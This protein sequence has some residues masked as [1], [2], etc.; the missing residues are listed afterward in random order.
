VIFDSDSEFSSDTVLLDW[1]PVEEAFAYELEVREVG[2]SGPQLIVTQSLT[3]SQFL[4]AI[5][6]LG[7]YEW[8]VRAFGSGD[9]Q[10]EWSETFTFVFKEPE[11][12]MVIDAFTASVS[13]DCPDPGI[14]VEIHWEVSGDPFG[15][16][17]ITRS[18][19]AVLV[20]APTS[21][22]G[23]FYE[24][25]LP[26]LFCFTYTLTATNSDGI[27]SVAS[28]IAGNFCGPG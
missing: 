16:L 13:D 24:T 18:A 6:E 3:P 19:G 1:S 20:H 11:P 12:L 14:C 9:R 21:F 2:F 4:F 10:S 8:R 15:T 27:P 26:E 28:A 23:T 5:P 25:G 17:E 7:T 22:T